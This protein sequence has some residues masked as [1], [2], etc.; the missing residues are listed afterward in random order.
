MCSTAVVALLVVF[1]PDPNWFVPA[2]RRQAALAMRPHCRPGDLAFSPDD[3]GL[4]TI[5]LTA[6]HA[7]VSHPLAPAH[8]ERQALVR[9]F[10][11]PM[12]PGERR[13]LL[14]RLK[15]ALLAL[16]GDAGPS[17]GGWLGEEAPFRQI[18]RVGAPPGTISVYLRTHTP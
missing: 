6:C 2:E 12:P 15:V 11:G 1:R 9:S 17:A 8:T 7:F 10:Y 3:I 14:V 16:P 4:F 13:A 18:A 5:A